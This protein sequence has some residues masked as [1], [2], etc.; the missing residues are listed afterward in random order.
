M[1]CDKNFAPQ[2]TSRVTPLCSTPHRTSANTKDRLSVAETE[3]MILNCHLDV[4]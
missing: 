3:T 1:S 4:P 2:H